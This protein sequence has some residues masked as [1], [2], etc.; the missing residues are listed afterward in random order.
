MIELVTCRCCGA[1]LERVYA[2][3]PSGPG[4]KCSKIWCVL[5]SKC[6]AHCPGLLSADHGCSS[7]EAGVPART[8]STV[9][10]TS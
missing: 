1:S 9:R 6:V 5:S 3:D 2:G 8:F 10:V 4:C 7:D